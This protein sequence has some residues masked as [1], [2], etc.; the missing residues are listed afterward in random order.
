MEKNEVK[1]NDICNYLLELQK[2]SEQYNNILLKTRE[3]YFILLQKMRC[4]VGK[5]EKNNSVD[6][7]E[8]SMDEKMVI[9]NIVLTVGVLY[10]MCKVQL[11]CKSS[12]SDS[13]IINK[14]EIEKTEKEAL[15]VIDKLTP[16]A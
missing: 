10:N 8:L 11:V 7:C 9:E 15:E 6:W 16:A 13:N 1:I 3:L 5:Y 4:I 2:T 14:I 12:N